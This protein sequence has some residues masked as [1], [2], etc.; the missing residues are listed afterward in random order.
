[1]M[2]NYLLVL[3]VVLDLVLGLFLL[4]LA[5]ER[6]VVLVLAEA[7]DDVVIVV[8]HLAVTARPPRRLHVVPSAAP[9]LS[10]PAVIFLAGLLELVVE[11][12]LFLIKSPIVS[13]GMRTIK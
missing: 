5:A 2:A 4:S 7:V 3:P 10:S 8:H 11:E 9:A 6:R 1:M 13:I 12:F